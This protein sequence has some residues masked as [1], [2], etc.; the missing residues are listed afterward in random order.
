MQKYSI[1]TLLAALSL[2]VLA[3]IVPTYLLARNTRSIWWNLLAWLAG[4]VAEV[5]AVA[6]TFLV[7]VSMNPEAA[8]LAIAMALVPPLP[9]LLI[10]PCAGVAAA[11]VQRYIKKPRP[12]TS[13]GS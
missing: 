11:Q 2:Y 10:T 9:M 13:T 5:G 1:M 3:A 7:V 4:F 8:P 6:A 12:R